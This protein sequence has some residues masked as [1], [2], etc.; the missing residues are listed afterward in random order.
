VVPR[1]ELGSV[2]A[3]I[4]SFDPEAFYSVDDIQAAARGVFPAPRKGTVGLPSPPGRAAPRTTASEMP[5]A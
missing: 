2:T 1:R 4:R 5:P 3:I